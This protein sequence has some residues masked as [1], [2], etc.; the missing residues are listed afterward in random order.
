MVHEVDV[1]N[2]ITLDNLFGLVTRLI[3]DGTDESKWPRVLE[4]ELKELNQ[5]QT[6]EVFD[7]EQEEEW[8]DVKKHTP[9]ALLARSPSPAQL[10]A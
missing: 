3:P 6:Q 8:D 10:P 1:N 7:L 5:M 4:A 9:D 2:Q